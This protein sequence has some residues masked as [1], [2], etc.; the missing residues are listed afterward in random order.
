MVVAVGSKRH[1]EYE[2]N[3]E[4]RTDRKWL[5]V[6]GWQRKKLM[7][8]RLHQLCNGKKSSLTEIIQSEEKL[9]HMKNSKSSELISRCIEF[10]WNKQVGFEDEMSL[11]KY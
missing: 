6:E 10:G 5:G 11:E 4:G 8:Q 2:T 9:L 1:R 7:I 3:W